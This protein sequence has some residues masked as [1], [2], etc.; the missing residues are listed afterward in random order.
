MNVSIQNIFLCIDALQSSSK[1]L[2]DKYKRHFKQH[3]ITSVENTGLG[4]KDVDLEKF[5]VD[6]TVVG[7]DE[8]AELPNERSQFID[9]MHDIRSQ[10]SVELNE[11]VDSESKERVSFIRGLAGIGKTALAK[12]IALR[13]ANHKIL[14]NFTHLYVL[15]CRNLNNER[16]LDDLLKREFFADSVPEGSKILFIID[17]I[18]EVVDLETKLKDKNSIIYQLLD[19]KSDRFV[20]SKVI[21]T[22]RPHVQTALKSR[23]SVDL[24]GNMKIYEAVGLSEKSVN[25]YIDLFTEKEPEKKKAIQKTVELSRNIRGLMSIP[26]YLNTLC[27]VSILTNGK[28]ILN[29]TELYCWLLFIF[30]Q[31]HIK[32]VTYV[33]DIFSNYFNFIKIFGK[34]SYQL[35]LKK[36]IVFNRNDFMK[37]LKELNKD[38]KI[39]DI[40]NVFCIDVGGIRGAPKLQFKHLT[41]QEFFASLHCIIE[42]TGPKIL[43][44]NNCFEIIT[45]M[46]GFYGGKLEA[47]GQ[48]EES[49][50]N[51]FANELFK[52]NKRNGKKEGQT[53]IL[54]VLNALEAEV[55]I[56]R[57]RLERALTFLW[58]YLDNQLKYDQEFINLIFQQFIRIMNNYSP[59]NYFRYFG[60]V[61]SIHQSNSFKL[62]QIA[63]KFDL[64]DNFCCVYLD[65]YKTIN[66]SLCK[67]F[68]HFGR[69]RAVVNSFES[70]DKFKL[71]VNHCKY[72]NH[73][74]LTDCKIVGNLGLDELKNQLE[75]ENNSRMEVLCI[76]NCQFDEKNL[77]II[78]EIAVKMKSVSLMLMKMAE[79]EW[80]RLVGVIEQRHRN[81]GMKLEVLNLSYCNIGDQLVER[82]RRFN[83]LYFYDEF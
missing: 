47:Q 81:N 53:F 75:D 80:E 83:Y 57:I 35:L 42:K 40:F 43:M 71:F 19:K 72:C 36:T 24:I 39:A 11:L 73:V 21:L 26:Q 52:R 41:L 17:G 13:W 70:V 44:K 12:Q 63:E 8:I 16:S 2:E 56:D 69:V 51:I 45:F 30:F 5:S 76:C 49:M 54:D 74:A 46:C 32:D 31:S 33:S 6:V 37:E 20:G 38:K 3:A 64:L 67:Y 27:C 23:Q 1:K 34:I 29:T 62:I 18:D 50:I 25:E 59:E 78:T 28:A 48:M 10:R 15:E 4:V 66:F 55:D 9:K 60:L 7:Q 79:K 58:E 68:K 61:S 82:V 65:L 14:Y 22:G 77:L